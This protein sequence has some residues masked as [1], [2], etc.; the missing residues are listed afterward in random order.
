MKI[1]TNDIK[2]N[3][4]SHIFVMSGFIRRGGYCIPHV[5]TRIKML[6]LYKVLNMVYI[7]PKIYRIM[8]CITNGVSTETKNKW[9]SKQKQL[10]TILYNEDNLLDSNVRLK[11]YHSVRTGSLLY[12]LS[13]RKPLDWY[14]YRIAINFIWLFICHTW[15]F[16]SK[17]IHS[18]TL[19][20]VLYT[21]IYMTE[22]LI[23]PSVTLNNL[24]NCFVV[25]KLTFYIPF[26]S[27]CQLIWQD[28]NKN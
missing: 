23:K 9:L 7:N 10:E 13:S 6:I 21:L 4:R 25:S 12:W 19:I 17:I 20:R 1:D 28:L 11:F 22:V 14:I 3:H 24:Y 5:N 8:T 15:V 2:W 18:F 26:V 16:Y 27:G